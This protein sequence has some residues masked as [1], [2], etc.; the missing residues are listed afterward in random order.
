MKRGEE[1]KPGL[2]QTGLTKIFRAVQL[3]SITSI[4]PSIWDAVRYP[5]KQLRLLTTDMTVIN[6][7]LFYAN[8]AR[9]SDDL[10]LMLL[11]NTIS[12]ELNKL[13]DDLKNEYRLK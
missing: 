7:F 11:K 4:T 1:S 6:E 13:I 10:S 12:N 3:R 8:S 5:E 9:L 2:F